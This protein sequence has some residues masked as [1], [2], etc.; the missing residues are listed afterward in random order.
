[1][2]IN[3]KPPP[4]KDELQEFVSNID[5]ELPGDYLDWMSQSNGAELSFKDNYLNLWP[6]TD[7]PALNRGY[8]IEDFAQGF[9]LIGSNGSDAAYAVSRMSGQIYELPFIGMSDEEAVFI[10]IDLKGLFDVFGR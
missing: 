2:N 4:T 1:M 10:S 8:K 9:F 3:K 5:F 6:L 7:L